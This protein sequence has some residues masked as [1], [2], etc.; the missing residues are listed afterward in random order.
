MNMMLAY[1]LLLKLLCTVNFQS[2][3][4][5]GQTVVVIVVIAA[6]A[7]SLLLLRDFV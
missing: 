4:F 6:A 3:A 1:L 5:R 2:G 7:T